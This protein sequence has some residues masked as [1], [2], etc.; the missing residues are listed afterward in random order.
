MGQIY[1]TISSAIPGSYATKHGYKV[2][3]PSGSSRAI[4]DFGQEDHLVLADLGKATGLPSGGESFFIVTGR[5]GKGVEGE[6]ETLKRI[7]HNMEIYSK[8]IEEL[9]DMALKKIDDPH[10]TFH[11]A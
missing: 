6:V 2:V 11:V 3:Y 9:A 8:E 7:I 1:A 4:F 10:F 5:L